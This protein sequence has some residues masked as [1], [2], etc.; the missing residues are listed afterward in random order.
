MSMTYAEPQYRSTCTADVALREGSGSRQF[1]GS[2]SGGEPLRLPLILQ[3]YYRQGRALRI[4]SALL[5][6]RPEC[7]LSSGERLNFAKSHPNRRH[8]E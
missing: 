2:R 6:A 3:K 5:S 4:L 8:Q 1:N 7:S